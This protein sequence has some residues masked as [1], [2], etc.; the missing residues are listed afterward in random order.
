MNDLHITWIKNKI[1]AI[2]VEYHKL[3]DPETRAQI[4]Q[5]QLLKPSE[6]KIPIK[7]L[8]AW[9]PCVGFLELGR[10]LVVPCA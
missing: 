8:N 10:S 2:D 1:L 4:I 9:L 3:E 6:H 5:H 7:E